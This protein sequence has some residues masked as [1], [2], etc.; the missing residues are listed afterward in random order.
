MIPEI[1]LS[2][3][4]DS[5][6]SAKI[7]QSLWDIFSDH[8]VKGTIISGLQIFFSSGA[9]FNISFL[10]VEITAPDFESNLEEIVPPVIIIATVGREEFF[11]SS[12]VFLER[13]ECFLITV[14][15]RISD[16]LIPM[17]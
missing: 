6:V 14:A 3:R 15:D 11:A 5:H 12:F 1:A 8:F 17:L 9:I 10:S 4:R 2:F 7:F 16:S 13:G